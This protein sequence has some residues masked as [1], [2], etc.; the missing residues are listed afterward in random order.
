[1]TDQEQLAVQLASIEAK[2]T[3]I[4]TRLFGNGQPGV[5]ADLESR[6]AAGERS[7][8]RAQGALWIVG[9]VLSL[10]TGSEILRLV[11]VHV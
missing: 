10:L 3:M 7:M 11:G 2:V 9:F 5:L 6:L 4:H 8:Y 1:M